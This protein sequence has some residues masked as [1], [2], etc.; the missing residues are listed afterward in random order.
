LSIFFLSFY[1]GKYVTILGKVKNDILLF[2]GYIIYRILVPGLGKKAIYTRY[3]AHP[4]SEHSPIR[5]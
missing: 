5:G 3:K 2:L 1:N 4:W